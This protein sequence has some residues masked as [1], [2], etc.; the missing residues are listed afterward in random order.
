MSAMTLLHLTIVG[1][2]MQP[3]TVEFGDHLTVI[4]G[5]S[6]RGKSFIVEAID[7]VLGAT[8]IKQITEA[9]GYTRILLGLR[10]DEG[11]V[12]TLSR[13]FDDTKVDIFNHDI[14]T[15][16]ATPAE[17]TLSAKHNAK[18]EK[19]ISRYL[20][21]LI[22]ADGRQLLRN[23]RG[24][25]TS[26]SFR[27]L[28]HLSI[29]SE[30]QMAAPRSPV[31]ASGQ[32][33]STTPEKSVFRYL[34]TGQDQP[35]ITQGLS[36]V[37]KK[38]GKGKIDLL[39]QVITSTRSSLTTET[40]EAELHKRLVRVE[41]SLSKASSSVGE[42]VSQRAP[43]LNQTRALDEWGTH[44][45]QRAREVRTLIARFDLLRRQYESDL[46]RLEMVAEAGNLLGYFQTGPCVFCGA[47]PEHQQIGH[48]LDETT[49]L[50]AAVIAE[51][52]KT[53][54]LRTDLLS[55][56][57]DLDGQLNGLDEEY[58]S[59][60]DRAE[61]LDLTLRDIEARL[62][63]LRSDHQED[64]SV[65]ATIQTDLAVHAQIQRLED[66]KAELSSAPETPPPARVDGIPTK[67]LHEFELMIH[68]ILQSW[69]VPGDNLVH[70]DQSTAEISVDGR[71]R[72]SRGK[73]MRSVIH[74]A[75][76]AALAQ[77][78]A[79]RE[80]PHPGFIVLDSPVLTYREPGD[81]Q[82]TPRVVEHFYKGLSDFA[83]QIIVIENGDPPED[84]DPDAAIYAF[85]TAGSDRAG[86]FPT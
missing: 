63:P 33:R 45:R 81:T 11:R 29:I 2:G 70:Y 41:M 51:M 36:D 25:L 69:Q 24:E 62:T 77:Y 86:F 58:A 32:E 68:R 19:N 80:H 6:D 20:L 27:Y 56:I 66:L 48:Q 42:L 46:D 18:S 59:S 84:L 17:V 83:S 78:A 14:R 74:A 35:K 82:L 40:S 8:K 49:S 76:T 50:Q 60:L 64:L 16:P 67:D 28:A 15:L 26:L 23:Q 10:L 53:T 21:K 52:R 38:V 73:G 13:P 4:Y 22:G 54:E 5:A 71:A 57:E 47:A 85:G 12:V 1:P 72:T 30:T 55:T 31:L 44:N 79:T 75:F 9:E 61:R 43:L 37:E 7:Y 34:L 39:D 65:R 3:A